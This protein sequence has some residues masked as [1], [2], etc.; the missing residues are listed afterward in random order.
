V[1]GDD[2]ADEDATACGN[3]CDS[4]AT[5]K[6]P[7]ERTAGLRVAIINQ[8]VSTSQEIERCGCAAMRST[9]RTQKLSGRRVIDGGRELRVEKLQDF[10]SDRILVGQRSVGQRPGG[11]IRVQ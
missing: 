6:L 4:P 9:P 11:P 7:F 2:V 3:P 5:M 10:H 1:H 8:D